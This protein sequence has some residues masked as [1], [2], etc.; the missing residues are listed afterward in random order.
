MKRVTI[1]IPYIMGPNNGIELRY[2][3]RSIE[4][5]FDHDNYHV[6]IIGEKPDWVTNVD[7]IYFQRLPEQD[8]RAFED[9]ILKLYTALTECDVSN[10]FI[11]T[12]DDVYFTSK[13]TLKDVSTPKAAKRVE[14]PADVDAFPGGSNWKEC[15]KRA[16]I[17]TGGKYVYETHIPR[18]FNKKKMLFIID[19]YEL[20]SKPMVIASV[21]YNHYA[22]AS[23]E[24][25]ILNDNKDHFRFMCRSL[26]EPDRLVELM[27][28]SMVTNNNHASLNNVFIAALQRIFSICSKFEADPV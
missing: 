20:L 18:Y 6:L 7:H 3:L 5:N 25:I 15:I 26:F 1:V 27:S 2:A 11:W 10:D 8:F 28:R 21:Y 12:Y 16:L 24:P 9:Q 22:N 23:V 14:K 13:I 4:K 17:A 19:K